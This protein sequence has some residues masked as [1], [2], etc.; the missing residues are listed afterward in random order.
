VQS[1]DNDV[2]AMPALSERLAEFD[3]ELAELA[4][5]AEVVPF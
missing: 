1:A 4:H 2:Y 5:T 3:R